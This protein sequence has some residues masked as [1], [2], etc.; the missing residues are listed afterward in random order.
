MRDMTIRKAIGLDVGCKSGATLPGLQAW[1]AGW[2]GIEL[3]AHRR[4]WSGHTRRAVGEAVAAT[5]P[6]SR[7]LAGDVCGLSGRYQRITWFLPFLFSEPLEAWGLP[8]RYLA[9]EKTLAH[10]LS[11]LE[12]GGF[13][14]ILNQGEAEAE[15]Q[16][17]LLQEAGAASASLGRVESLLSPYKKARYGWRVGPA[18]AV[19][20]RN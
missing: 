14:L 15:E 2:D 12:E 18:P 13:L 8:L 9:P 10:V 1:A 17:R 5:L 16:G 11:L 3:D 4:Y 20:I 19:A 6:G 7:Y